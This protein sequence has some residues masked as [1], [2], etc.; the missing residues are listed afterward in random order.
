M[1]REPTTPEVPTNPTVRRA[2]IGFQFRIRGLSFRAVAKGEDVSQQAFSA[3]MLGGGS[4]HLQEVAARLLDLTPQQLFPE[5]YDASGR[6]L[7]NT[8]P[9]N[10]TTRRGGGNGKSEEAA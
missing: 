10:R 9:P 4:S 7:L 3:A 6:R 1:K 5:L 8:R 2:W